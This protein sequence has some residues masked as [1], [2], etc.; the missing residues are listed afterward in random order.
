M[1]K[2]VLIVDDESANR[3]MLESLLKGYDLEVISAENGKDALDKARLNPPDLIVA[4]ILMPVMDGYAL[5]RQWKSDDSLKQIPFVFY[6]ATYT[7]PKDEAFAL[8]LGAERFILKPQEPEILMNILKEV[9]EGR[10]TVKQAAAMPLGEEMEFFRQHNEILFKKLEKKMLD[11]EIANQEL[12]TLEERYR[13]SF[14]NVTDVICTIDSD[15]N[16]LSMS[17]SVEKILGYKP[18]DFIGRPVSHL[19]NILTPESFE[20]AIANISLILKGDIMPATIYRFVAK[21]ETIKYGEVSGSPVMRDGK[22]IGIVFVAR[23]ITKRKQAEEAL[24][25]SEQKYRE[26]FDFLPIPVYEMDLEA[27][28]TSANR[29]IHETFGNIEEDLKKGFKVWQILSPEN[30]DKS[31]KN[32]QRLLKGEQIRGTEYTLKRLD[33]SVFPAVAISSVIYRNG[34]PVGLRGAI[35]DITERYQTEALLRKAQKMEAIGTLAGGIAHDF[36]NIL[37]AILGYTDMALAN[38]K[39]EDLNRNY[40]EQVFKA[41]ERARDLVKQILTFSRQQEQERK[42]VLVAPIIKEGLKLLRPSLPSTIQITQDISKAPIMILADPTQVHQIIINLCTNAAHAMREKGGVLN[43]QLTQERI[44]PSDTP[45]HLGLEARDYA[46][47]TVTDV[48]HGIAASVM[49]RIFDPFFTTKGPGEGTGLGLSVVYGIARHMGGAIDI[50]S[51]LGKGTTATVYL[52]MIETRASTVEQIQKLIPGG[53]E[54]ILYVDDEPALVELG[55]IML[56]SLGYDV[57]ARTSSIEAL[58]TFLVRPHEFDLVITD[59]TMPN[60]TGIDLAKE[61]LKIRPDLPVILCSGFSE[62]VSEEKAKSLGINQFIM[63]PMTKREMAMAVR[64]VLDKT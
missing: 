46:K 29:A 49:D 36:N 26:M 7:E 16:L 12:K 20:Q 19:K 53:S 17:P 62:M 30:I 1:I 47:L 24:R 57:I 5:C 61:L 28:V 9:L 31:K 33:G 38:T 27:N 14:E 3:Y 60:M 10:D 6:T 18:Q 63:K 13:L 15:L 58:K 32:I 34:K 56:T 41:G 44:D 11:L 4:D 25:E 23:D 54:R 51:E 42:P 45:H 55:C 48:G 40:L 22:I 21:D 52:P 8:S 37:G 35:V 64:E 39:V 43:I 50:S 2:K 59:T